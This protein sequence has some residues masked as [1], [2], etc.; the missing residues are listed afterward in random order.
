M[1]WFDFLPDISLP[2]HVDIDIVNIGDDVDGDL[3]EG[4][5]IDGDVIEGDNVDADYAIVS[6]GTFVPVDQIERVVA[7]DLAGDAPI[8]LRENDEE[9]VIDPANL[10]GDDEWETVVKPGLKRGWE[11]ERAVSTRS[12]YPI[13]LQAE[14]NIT[15]EKI[16]EIRA[17]FSDKIF[18][19]D[20]LLLQSSLTIDRAMNAGDGS[21]FS[22]AELQR[23]K[24]D[25]ADKY[26]DAAFSLPSMCTSG[27]FDE[28]ELFR[29]V[30]EEMAA[31][32]EYDIDDYDS[33]F[34][35]MIRQ[36]P[37]VAYA[38]TSQSASELADIVSGKIRRFP[39]YDIPLPYIDVR[40]LGR[41]NHEKIRTAMDEI[42]EGYDGIEYDERVGDEELIVRIEAES[43][44]T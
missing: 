37:F 31:D 26:H 29:A 27:Y 12:A 15:D 32:P 25:L 3:V 19:S 16:S 42:E 11:E 5:A 23:R 14:R 34:R 8:D 6:E 30:Y 17:F 39:G 1:S 20:F 44:P 33:V 2:E 36:K 41:S 18:T 7:G 35:T 43:I 40:G 28:D 24:R 10:R 21:G 4:D 13:L 22:N 9:L 38:S